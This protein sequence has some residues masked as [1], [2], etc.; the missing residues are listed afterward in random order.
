M[1]NFTLII[2]NEISDGVM[3]TKDASEEIKE[4]KRIEVSLPPPSLTDKLYAQVL[5]TALKTDSLL[6]L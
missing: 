4:P 3:E 1:N 6:D 2:Q 5:Y